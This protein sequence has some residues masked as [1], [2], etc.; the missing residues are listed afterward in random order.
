[1][2]N[3]IDFCLSSVAWPPA[4]E[5][6]ASCL[7][8]LPTLETLGLRILV[9]K[10]LELLLIASTLGSVSRQELPEM[11]DRVK[12]LLDEFSLLKNTT[13]LLAVFVVVLVL[14]LLLFAAMIC[15]TLALFSGKS[16]RANCFWPWPWPWLVLSSASSKYQ[17]FKF[18]NVSSSFPCASDGIGTVVAGISSSFT[19]LKLARNLV[20]PELKRTVVDWGSV[21]WLLM[22]LLAVLKE[23]TRGKGVSGDWMRHGDVVVMVARLWRWVGP[24]RVLFSRF[25]LELTELDCM[26]FLWLA[27]VLLAVDLAWV[28]LWFEK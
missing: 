2:A 8:L 6:L 21:A 20:W 15:C 13:L 17:R 4:R 7:T 3:C 24:A 18:G 1:M 11:A 19:F 14:E 27:F 26:S 22:R 25:K 28:G 5:L 23:L 16:L 10:E 12:F 9:V